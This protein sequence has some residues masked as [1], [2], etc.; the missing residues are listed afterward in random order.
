MGIVTFMVHTK[1]ASSLLLLRG[2]SPI[3]EREAM[4]LFI[5]SLRRV[6]VVKTLAA[7]ATPFSDICTIDPRP[8]LVVVPWPDPEI[9]QNDHEL[10][11]ELELHLAG[12]V[13]AGQR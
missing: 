8:V 2:S 12:A 1:V 5:D 11:R 3:A 10:V 13:F 4:T 7:S 6:K 9:S